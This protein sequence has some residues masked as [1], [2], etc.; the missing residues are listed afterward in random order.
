MQNT[1]LPRCPNCQNCKILLYP[2]Q[3]PD[4]IQLTQ[5]N[6]VGAVAANLLKVYCSEC[7]WTGNL[8]EVT[9]RRL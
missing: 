5:I 4:N 6:Y 1:F 8:T 9:F 2:R 3:I 7:T